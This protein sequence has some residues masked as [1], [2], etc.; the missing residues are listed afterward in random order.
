M[1]KFSHL[2]FINRIGLLLIA[3][4]LAVPLALAP[5]TQQ[6]QAANDATIYISPASSSLQNGSNKTFTIYVNTGSN[7]INA[8]QA[9]VSYD[10][11]KFTYISLSPNTTN[12]P[13]VA[14]QSHSNGVITIASGTTSTVTGTKSV[15][16]F[17]LKAKVGSG[18]GAISVNINESAAVY[19][20]TDYLA[21]VSGATVTFTTPSSGGGGGR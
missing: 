18:T 9:Q 16:T 8:V 1:Q 5:R 3:L 7:S 6:V 4:S 2:D 12:F 20:G 14:E 10:T 19:N 13:F 17:T 21:S 15:G 11:S